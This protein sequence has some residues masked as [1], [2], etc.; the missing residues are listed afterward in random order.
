MIGE[1]LTLSKLES[2][3]RH[4]EDYFDLAEVV[5][6][7][8]ED[9]T[10]EAAP[11]GVHFVVEMHPSDGSSGWIALG[12]GKLIS[13]AIENIVRNALRFSRTGQQINM[14]LDRSSEVL[15][16]LVVTDQGP[17]VA[18]TLLETLF[19]PFV[20]GT[21]GDGNGFGLGLAI[22]ERAVVAHGGTIS[23]HNEKSGG[24][25]ITITLPSTE[26]E[27]QSLSHNDV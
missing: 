10:F 8:V 3:V 2:G 4:F 14:R 19:L 13:H 22:A 20:Q 26:I 12:N 11:M 16:R 25:T 7:V 23:A 17:G 1:L 27:P 21:G 24:L 9:A 6:I 15:F 5:K 18:D